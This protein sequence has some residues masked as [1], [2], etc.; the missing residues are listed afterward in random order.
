MRE[1]EQ[2]KANICP[3]PLEDNGDDLD[4]D[5][6]Q[7]LKKQ[8][9]KNTRSKANELAGC[10]LSLDDLSKWV[11]RIQRLAKGATDSQSM[12]NLNAAL[13]IDQSKIATLSMDS[14]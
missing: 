6:L 14:S 4:G 7:I 12:Q 3:E 1:T 13:S 8:K 9:S 5:K 2:P 11:Q 10:S